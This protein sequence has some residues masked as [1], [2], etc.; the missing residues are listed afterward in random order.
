MVPSALR[1]YSLYI[2]GS[3]QI[4][5]ELTDTDA[6]NFLLDHRKFDNTLQII[7]NTVHVSHSPGQDMR[8]RESTTNYY[9]AQG[10][11]N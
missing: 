8:F 10:Y 5:T 9:T 6:N 2:L 11:F 4:R 3:R 7:K 1:V